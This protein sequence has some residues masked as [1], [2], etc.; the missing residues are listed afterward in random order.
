MGGQW[1]GWLTSPQNYIYRLPAP[2]LKNP[3]TRTTGATVDEDKTEV[4]KE[5][6]D[7]HDHFK[8]AAQART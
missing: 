4:L 7:S 2:S 3:P 5:R 6:G 1:V 8:H